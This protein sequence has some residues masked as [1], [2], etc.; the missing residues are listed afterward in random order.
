MPNTMQLG[1]WSSPALVRIMERGMRLPARVLGRFRQSQLPTPLAQLANRVRQE[2]LTYL[3][4][5]KLDKLAGSVLA[6]ERMGLGGA[7]I[8]AG[9]ALGGS[10]I[11]LAAAKDQARPLR[12]YDVFGMIPPPSEEDGADVHRRYAVITAGKSK[13]LKGNPYYGYEKHVISKVEQSFAR[14]GFPIA[15]NNVEL[16]MGRLE[17][18]MAVEQPI[19]VAHIDVDWYAPVKVSLERIAPRLVPGGAI[20]LDDYFDW[21]GCRRATDEFLRETSIAFSVDRSAGSMKLIKR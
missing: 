5:A 9:C 7:L 17:E 4:A 8:E 1:K 12:V 3:S 15:E 10:A 16:I 18:T 6:A 19:A 2:G 13:G 21:S 14:H 11:L 20:L